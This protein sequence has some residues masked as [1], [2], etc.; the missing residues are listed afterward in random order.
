VSWSQTPQSPPQNYLPY[1][2]S[3]PSQA[4]AIVAL[5]GGILSI[6]LIVAVGPF[7]APFG[8]AAVV[9]GI[10]ALTKRHP[11]RGM[12]LAGLI[13]GA[14]GI[15]LNI[16]VTLLIVIVYG[17]IFAL[18][19][20][21]AFDG[22][23]SDGTSSEPWNDYGYPDEGEDGLVG[24][25]AFG[26]VVTLDEYAVSVDGIETRDDIV[27]ADV[28]VEFTGSGTGDAYMDLFGYLYDGVE[29]EYYATD[30]WA[31]VNPDAAD[32]PDLNPGES[33]SFEM[34]FDG[35]S[36]P[37]NSWVQIVDDEGYGAYANWTDELTLAGPS[38]TGV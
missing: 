14:V 1:P 20:S 30:C 5:V 10:I 17:G 7:A 24:D 16:L 2:P 22:A 37:E 15:V 11:G 29:D 21:G 18:G 38:S 34:C 12:A 32:L 8:I 36:T 35:V 13:T 27:Y 3:R 9:T 4:L 31:E 19:I 6:L 26:D 25:Y 33:A 23:T 28:T